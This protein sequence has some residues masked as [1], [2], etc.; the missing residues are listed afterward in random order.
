MMRVY[1]VLLRLYPKSFRSAF[2]GEIAATLARVESEWADGG[3]I[4]RI[5]LSGREILGLLAGMVVQ[6]SRAGRSGEELPAVAAASVF[7]TQGSDLDEI[8]EIE[9][10]IRF[11]RNK[12]IDCIANHKFEGARLHAREEERA[13]AQL[14]KLRLS[15]LQNSDTYGA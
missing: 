12:T 5:L 14:M 6:H 13:R 11:H 1:R 9:R 8:A 3:T 10:S 15:K 2:E 7:S 4:R